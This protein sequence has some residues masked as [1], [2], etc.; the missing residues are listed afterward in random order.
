MNAL[1]ILKTWPGVEKAN[2]ATLLASP[3]WRLETEYAGRPATLRAGTSP[4]ETV[5]LVVAFDDE[6][7]RLRIADSSSFADL[8]LLWE[9]RRELPANLLLALVERECGS[10][11]QTLENCMRRQL[12]VK[13]FADGSEAVGDEK[14]VVLTTSD[15]EIAFAVELS[16]GLTVEWGRME[17]LDVAHPS[18]RGLVR[19][20]RAEYAT[21]DLTE[22]ELSKLVSGGLLLMPEDALASWRLPAAADDLVHVVSAEEA[23]VTFAQVADDEWPAVAPPGDAGVLVVRRGRELMRGSVVDFGLQRA[24]RL[25]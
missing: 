22:D 19:P 12:S 8:H 15:A 14:S 1:E 11:L 24:V 10:L 5:D 4:T 13:G 6:P 25:V 9:R 23:T 2:A 7:H 20:V 21:Y 16:S 18:V 3:A 17:N